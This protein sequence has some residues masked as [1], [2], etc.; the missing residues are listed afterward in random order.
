MKNNYFEILDFSKTKK[1]EWNNFCS[2][3]DNAWLWHTYESIESKTFWINHSNLSFS[4]I[5]RSN[6]NK[7]IAIFP[8]FLVKK[9]K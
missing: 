9:K 8:I 5:D 4:I 6:R 2:K 3:S 1:K 7:I